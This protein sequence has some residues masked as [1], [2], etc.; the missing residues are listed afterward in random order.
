MNRRKRMLSDLDQDIRDHIAQETQDNIDRGMSPEEARYAA[1]RKF[2]NVTRVQEETREVWSLVWLEDLLQD[3][4]YG[5]R[6]L[7]KS[8]GFTAV[9]ILTLAL[10]IGANTAIFGF[11][12]GALM[13]A[14]PVSDPQNL[15]LLMWSAHGKATHLGTS[16]YGDCKSERG[17]AGSGGCSFSEPLFREIQS[18]GIFSQLAAF[19]GSEGLV[20][21]GNGAASTVDTA[22]YVSGGYFQTLGVRPESGRL[23]G[24]ADDS[25]S[26]SPVVVLSY[27][28]WKS[29]F[30]GSPSA[31][32]K[33]IFL[34][35]V[36]FTIIGVAEPRF[37][38]LSPGNT[39]QMWLPLST[40]RQLL[41]VP[42][43]N[44]DADHNYWRLVMVA[45]T[46]PEIPRGQAQAAVNVL[47]SNET[48][49]SAK[50]IFKPED[51]PAVSLVPAETGLTGFTTE[52]A[53]P[54]YLIML[55]VGVVLLIACAN[56][57]GLLLSRAA[58]RQKEMAVRFALGAR[59]GR[60]V[61]QLLTESLLLSISGGALGL[62]LA[63]W[64]VAMINAFVAANE[65]ISGAAALN[66]GLD[67]RVLLFTAAV[68]ILTG[69]LFG[70]APALRGMRVDL[71]PALKEAVGNLP[72][73]RPLAR[74]LVRWFTMGNA[75]VV[76]Q[77][78]LTVVV[79]AGAGLLVRT[80]QNLR[81]VDPGFDTRNVLT[82]SVD[83]A[84]AGYNRADV[85]R[86][87]HD[88]QDRLAAIPGVSSVS[89][90]WRPLLS[91]GLW[92]TGFHL[93]G[94]P[95][96]ETEVADMFP[97][98]LD[99][100]HT[101]GIPLRRGR[102]LEAPDF[103]VAA[104]DA[105]ARAAQEERVAASLKT[106]AKGMAEQ[107]NK[108]TA[109][110]P[111]VPVIVNEVLIRKYFPNANPIGIR[112][113]NHVA[114]DAEP[115]SN[116]GWEIVGVVADAKYNQ[117]RREI[118]PTI[119]APFTGQGASFSLRT[120]ANPSSFT[121]QIRSVVAQL[122]PNLPVDRIRTET[123]Q[124]ESQLTVERLIARLSGFFGLLALLLSCIGLY[125]LLSYEV[126]RRTREIGIR[127]ALGA[128]TAD[129]LRLIIKQGIVLALVGAAAGIGVALAVTRYLAG[130]LYDV[131][132]NDPVTMIAV[133]M[134]L[135]LV[136]LAACYIPARRAMRV[137]P[138][139]ALRYE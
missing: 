24:S 74:P 57:A 81:S 70:L 28:Y 113:G 68:S 13:R 1:L 66:S 121:P 59:R 80:L 76:A 43:D 67:A 26:A 46:K 56:V 87:Y 111:P 48:L 60:I 42:W 63:K 4:S 125:G 12:D 3:V 39:I 10:G 15:V 132:A 112:F 40:E 89:Y 58:A 85:D 107:N 62:F 115:D 54:I 128:Q 117:L 116:P 73:G 104:K 50:P 106:G 65:E 131:H 14:L 84:T 135:A 41:Q 31:V 8:P 139:V 33:T 47:F 137:D 127:L 96:D 36:A 6:M 134:L 138:I 51:G 21:T 123:Q 93:S 32:G 77:V 52:I 64:I 17:P 37:D 97:V 136:A 30:A 27:A 49:H 9:A 118:E 61:R 101:M 82:F 95:E 18:Q 7:R 86:F 126:A 22:D 2:G 100:F 130:I 103:L 124:I 72:S 71:T 23:I 16:S 75:L 98:G 90:S 20:L 105:A 120:A 79:L 78:A 11:I 44:R 133:A 69:I 83:P 102:E 29:A 25:L 108:E 5:L 88:L 119:Y 19:S 91:G 53:T 35:R 38:A 55:A 94:K 129:V 122:D 110:L 92:T 34:N 45:R 114:T 109:N 99:F